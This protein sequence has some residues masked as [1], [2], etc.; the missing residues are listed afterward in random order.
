MLTH[1]LWGKIP[2]AD[3]AMS[4]ELRQQ[5]I[6]DDS[7]TL[8]PL[9]MIRRTMA[10]RM[11]Q[12]F[13]QIPHFSLRNKLDVRPLQNTRSAYNESHPDQRIS[14]NDVM[15]K[16]VATAIAEVPAVNVSFHEKGIL[17][18]HHV[19]IAVA[20]AIEGGLITPI[21]RAAETKSVA[22]ISAEIKDMA[23]RAKRKRLMP[24]EYIGGTFTI[25]NLGMFGVTEFTSIINPPQACILSVGSVCEE[26]QLIDGQICTRP[27]IMPTLNCDHRAI[28]GATGAAWLQA[29]R[30]VIETPEAWLDAD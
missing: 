9:D 27:V 11:T 23:D 15:V 2:T 26:L 17:L 14:F 16:A 19:D 20:V 25:S 7:Y 21:V 3:D 4:E 5:G 10:R 8:Q 28:D 30:Q 22:T 12:S 13:T 24:E 29:F 18:H 6:L 1:K